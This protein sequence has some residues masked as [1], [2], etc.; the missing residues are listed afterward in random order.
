MSDTEII[1]HQFLD[2]KSI[3]LIEN[4]ALSSL[5]KHHLRLM[6]HCLACFKLMGDKTAHF[7]FPIEAEQLQWC[8]AQRFF[9]NE[10]DF[11]PVF[12]KQLSVAES[13]LKDVAMELELSPMALTVEDL[14]LHKSE[15][16][17]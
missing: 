8:S 13:F 1:A 2:K 17:R 10:K 7:D 16:K 3:E 12:L 14:I 11:I 9:Q 4:S 5:D 15:E 6:A